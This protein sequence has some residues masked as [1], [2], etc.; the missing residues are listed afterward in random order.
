M[1]MRLVLTH[2]ALVCHS[3]R[4]PDGGQPTRN[5]KDEVPAPSMML[6]RVCEEMS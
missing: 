6:Q 3:S 2:P 4:E 5:S 1:M